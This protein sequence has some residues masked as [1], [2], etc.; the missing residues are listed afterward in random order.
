MKFSVEIGFKWT[1]F[2]CDVF[3]VPVATPS[4][5]SPQVSPVIHSS[6]PETSPSSGHHRNS[7]DNKVPIAEPITPGM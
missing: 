4:G 7:P 2:G 3:T 1:T 6:T 5:N